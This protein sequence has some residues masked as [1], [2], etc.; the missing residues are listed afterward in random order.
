[1]NDKQLIDKWL[2]NT[3]S[4][5][6]ADTVERILVKYFG[7]DSVK[8]CGS[9]HQYRVK[10]S[11]LVD[12]SNFGIGGY[13]SVPVKNGQRVKGFYLKNIARTVKR[14]EEVAKG[15]EEEEYYDKNS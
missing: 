1:M 11:A 7:P 14:L 10:H 9:S 8:K 13:L 5:E 15:E 2:N 6:S 3:P 4:D 12:L